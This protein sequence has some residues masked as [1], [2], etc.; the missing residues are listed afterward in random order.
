MGFF[1][2]PNTSDDVRVEVGQGGPAFLAGVLPG[3]VSGRYRQEAANSLCRKRGQR[4]SK[5][6][7]LGVYDD[8]DVVSLETQ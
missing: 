3:D 8:I 1:V 7:F 6:V 2:A 5:G 4:D